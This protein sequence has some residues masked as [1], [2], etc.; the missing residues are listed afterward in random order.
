MIS[1]VAAELS[2][3]INANSESIYLFENKP[4]LLNQIKTIID[5]ESPIS[6]NALFRKILK[7]WNTSRAGGKMNNYLLETL[8]SIPNLQT[9]ESYQKFYWSENLLPQ[10]LDFYRDNSV[11]KRLI[12]EIAPEEISVAIMELMHSSLSLNKD[13][14][15]RAVCKAFGFAKVGSQIDSV[16]NFSVEDLVEKGVLKEVDGRIVLG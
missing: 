8:N 9:S 15:I 11:E 2:S 14:L 16:V 10:N 5:T 7:L 12:D 3:E 1:Y 13:E 6:Q 4:V